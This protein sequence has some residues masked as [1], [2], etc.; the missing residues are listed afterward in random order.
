MSKSKINWKYT[1]F[2]IINPMVAIVGTVVLALHHHINPY[3]LILALVFLLFSGLS[4]TAGYHR[5]FSHGAYKVH[6]FMKWFFVLFGS[7]SFEGGVLEWCTDH[8]N[9]HRYTDTPR[10]P[11]NINQSFWHAHIGWIFTLH[12]DDRDYA[13]VEDLMQDPLLRAQKKHFSLFAIGIG[14]LLPMA[15]ASLW[16]DPWGGL[17]IAGALRMTIN[18]HFT[19]LINSAC[20]YFG[21]QTYND[22]GT[23]RDNWLIAFFTYGEGYHNF[24][25]KFPLDYRNGI[26][27]YDFDPTK[28]LIQLMCHCGLAS[29]LKKVEQKKILE[30]RLRM[31]EKRILAKA[32]KHSGDLHS[33]VSQLVSPARDAV[34]NAIKA[35]E[36]IEK[37]LTEF[38]QQHQ[39]PNMRTVIQDSGQKLTEY[40]RHLAKAKKDLKTS[41]STWK[42]LLAYSEALVSHQPC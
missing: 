7:A 6:R 16:G 18:H 8:R 4:I 10:D 31:D 35:L 40:K 14:F 28:W 9:H 37:L 29:D 33:H 27:A 32:E 34:F 24:H 26:R 25:H 23:A 12:D 30:Y 38:K 11:Y 41:L 3:T 19:F 22:K 2:F 5:C 21:K 36:S 15:I 1:L 17:I 13:N 42:H 39:L 20:H